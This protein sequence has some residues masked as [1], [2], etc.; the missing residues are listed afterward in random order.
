MFLL[1]ID[2]TKRDAWWRFDHYKI[3][4]EINM[5]VEIVR[6]DFKIIIAPDNIANQ[7]RSSSTEY[8]WGIIMTSGDVLYVTDEEQAKI[9][10]VLKYRDE[11]IEK[12]IK[13]TDSIIEELDVLNG[14]ATSINTKAESIKTNTAGTKSNTDTIKANS[15]AIKTNT[16]NTYDQTKANGTLLSQIKTVCDNI[17]SWVRSH[18]AYSN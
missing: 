13:N 4:D 3:K 15:E 2:N 11:Q 6:N 8:P 12:L 9:A 16:A 14:T 1:Y 18:Y 5:V 7:V 17:Y 10:E